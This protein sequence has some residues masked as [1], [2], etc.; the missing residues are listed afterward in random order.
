M[1]HM[2]NATTGLTLHSP[3]DGGE[4]TPPL[5]GRDRPASTPERL[6]RLPGPLVSLVVGALYFASAQYVIFL[7]DPVNAGAGFWPPA[8]VSLAALLMLPR[9]RWGWVLGAVAVAEIGG[10]A[11]QGYPLLA[12][13][14]WAAGNV[15]EPFV[16]ALL[17]LRFGDGGKMAPVHNLLWFLGCAVLAG[18]LI[19]ALVGSI[20]TALAFDKPYLTV[21]TKWWVGDGVGVLVVAPLLLAW[22]DWRNLSVRRWEA[23]VLAVLVVC[24]SG[25][26]FYPRP[27]EWA[28]VLPYLT[29]PLL[30]WAALRFGVLGAAAAGFVLAQWANL[31]TALGLGPLGMDAA[32][33]GHTIT[34]LQVFIAILLTT[35]LFVAALAADL[36][37]RRV[38][39]RVLTD[40]AAQLMR[41]EA[42]L[43][44]YAEVASDWLWETDEQLRFTRFDGN[45]R[46]SPERLRIRMIG[47]TR[48][49]AAGNP[50]TAE[51]QE[52]RRH[53][54][55][56]QP[57]YDFHYDVVDE[58]GQ[59]RHL[60]S[61]GRPVFDEAGRFLGYRGVST[62]LTERMRIQ[63][64][65]QSKT[66]L[67]EATLEN[68]DQGLMVMDSDGHI[69]LYN[70][71]ALDLLELPGELLA[72]RPH[73]QAVK[74]HQARTEDFSPSEDA[75]LQLTTSRGFLSDPRTY[76][77]T[78]PNGTVLE[79]RTVPLPHGGAVRTYTDITSRRMAETERRAS[80]ERYRALVHASSSVVWR[81]SPEGWTIQVEGLDEF[82]GSRAGAHMG[83]GWWDT[84]HPEDRDRVIATWQRCFASQQ[85]CLEE[86]RMMHR[87]GQYRWVSCRGVLIRNGEGAAQEWVGTLADIHD[88]KI[89]S[90]QLRDSEERYRA[91]VT[92]TASILWRAAPDGS[93]FHI[94]GFDAYPGPQEGLLGFGWLELV[95][96]EDRERLV[97]EWQIIVASGEPG[98]SV[99]RFRGT[100][101]AYRW[102]ACRAAPLKAA[103]GAIKEWVGNLI[104]IH[105]RKQAEDALRRSREELHT[106]L[107]ANRNILEHSLD[108]ICTIDEDG[109][110]AQ[111][112]PRAVD[113]WGYT[114]EELIGRRYIELVHPEDVAK[115]DAI[116][117]QIV[118][119]TPTSGFEN[120]YIRKDGSVVPILW[121]AVWSEEH[122]AM[123]SVARDLTE[124]L[125][126]EEQLRQAHKMEAVG[127]L[128]GG[129]AHDFNNLLTVILGNAEILAEDTVG[130]AE[131]RS[132]SRV[133][134]ETAERGAELTQ[135]LLAFGRRHPLRPVRLRLNHVVHGM[136]P[137]LQR[138]LGAHIELRTEFVQ[139]PL[140]ALTDRT[141]LENAIL[142]LAVN[143]RDAMAKG[144]TLTI[145]TGQRGAQHG[146]GQL[147][148]GQ[149]VVF[150]TV[151][152]TGAGMTP[153]VLSRVF[154]PFFTTK[155][156]GKGSGL[157]LSMVYGFANQAGGHVS[158]TSE[159]G[160]GTSVTI[161][162]P[163]VVSQQLGEAA[164]EPA[165][166][167]LPKGKERIL[168]VEDEPQVLQYVSAQLLSL[169]YDMTAVP[170]GPDALAI[171]KRD[172]NFDLLLT[173]LVLPNGM[174]GGDLAR[175]AKAITPDLKVMFTSGYSE[176]MLQQDSSAEREIP[177]L[178]KP[179]R[180]KDLAEM[181]RHVL[182]TAPAQHRSA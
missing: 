167:P 5:R 94:A 160:R 33:H 136:M 152:D 106:A 56:R 95:H 175:I 52:H 89:A 90:E 13:V 78:R 156:T 110:F 66:M 96:P 49:E 128:T 108:V 63:A 105:E 43:R 46:A 93:I 28:V 54:A 39:E 116:A 111:V 7:N 53:H 150:V 98:E 20:G 73:I 16:A 148:I 151:S 181:L 67:L 82:S 59:T 103:D 79:I 58:G 179:Y 113:V 48:W 107:E 55:Q 143:A 41:S 27:S 99:F 26:A 40:Q 92:A 109:A 102:V 133:I 2:D 146:E 80:E 45:G 6:A 168:L 65:L 141:L 23:P 38:L 91:L 172:K 14:P 86:H 31:A 50:E 85:P 100:S 125:K 178:R 11:L 124:R 42:R 30:I 138:T 4:A 32:P 115:T 51:W 84:I 9:H 142:N 155:E 64:Q 159:A 120:R 15:V 72:S 101:N 25:L 3:P 12:S 165:A 147:P 139:T 123:F 62:D 169:G 122:K 75:V 97:Q 161:V 17:L 149:D 81:A 60:T 137:L 19:G 1:E 87:S 176:D 68:M 76:E 145:A 154:E 170:D 114:P 174:S 182:E 44:D 88:Q 69:T 135:H 22:R 126:T 129:V 157:G 153:D 132:L 173:D 163:A 134:L 112:S 127:Q 130:P 37:E 164:N 57:F 8:G 83:F 171:L 177:L 18:P 24:V 131:S 47:R 61:S 74:D 104:D 29:V 119:G 71:R 180:R 70:G 21:V 162:L 118:S 35:G 140:S 166:I 36:T 117:A 144:G 10:G 121:S 77:R 158:I 34:L